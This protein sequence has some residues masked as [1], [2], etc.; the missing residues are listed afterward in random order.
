VNPQPKQIQGIDGLVYTPEAED[1]I[2]H[3]V[4]VTFGTDAGRRVLEYLRNITFNRIHGPEVSDST[5]RHAEGSR[6]IV[7]I[8]ESRIAAARKKHS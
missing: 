5:L 8:L 6:F 1:E 3:L 7:A 4:A 2:N